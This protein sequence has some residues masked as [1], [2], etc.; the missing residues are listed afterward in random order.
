MEISGETR[1]VGVI[2]HPI[3]HSLSPKMHNASFVVSGLNYVYVPMDVEPGSLMSAVEG[4]RA[5][6]FRGFNVTLP[7]K[8]A[9]IPLLDELD[10]TAELTG[11]VNTVTNEVGRLRGSNTDAGGFVEACREVGVRFPGTV[12]M[13]VGAGGAAAA[14]GAAILGEGARELRIMNRTQRRAEALRD[15]LRAAFPEAT[16]SVYVG[17][18]EAV[19]AGADAIINTTYLGMK[20]DDPLPVPARCFEPGMMIC[21]A[22]YRRGKETDFIRMA[23]ERGLRTASGE[24]MLL[25]Q[26]VQAQ[27]MWTGREPAI[28]AM[29]DALSA[30]R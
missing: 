12:V 2:G 14:I 7:H 21:D 4:L 24:R 23:R 25:F 3:A 28:A 9:I 16:V 15:R 5:L 1:L 26:G 22:V 30:G 19:T 6:G 13:M 11:A 8:Q 27:R 29:R 10:A 20:D 17:D 18:P